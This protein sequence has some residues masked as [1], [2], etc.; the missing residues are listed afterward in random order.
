VR[1]GDGGVA[2]VDSGGPFQGR[3]QD[4]P[5]KDFRRT[6]HVI[7]A[8]VVTPRFPSS[9]SDG[10]EHLQVVVHPPRGRHLGFAVIPEDH[11]C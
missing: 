4:S 3:S 2:P 11:A 10:S 1:R 9:G 6:F 8:F 5:G 7:N